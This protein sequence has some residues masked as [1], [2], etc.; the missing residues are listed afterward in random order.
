MQQVPVLITLSGNLQNLQ[1]QATPDPAICNKKSLIVYTL[2]N[3]SGSPLSFCQVDLD[4]PNAQFSVQ[5]ISASQIELLDKDNKA[6]TYSVYL[7]V[8]DDSGNR[9]RS[10]DPQVVNVPE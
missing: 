2:Q 7:W 1:W 3:N 5:S 6:G 9:Y 4:P 10:P 8:Q